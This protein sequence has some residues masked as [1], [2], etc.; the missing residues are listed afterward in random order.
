M[1]INRGFFLFISLIE[2]ASV[3]L[4]CPFS[5]L[6]VDEERQAEQYDEGGEGMMPPKNDDG[7]YEQPR[8]GE[9]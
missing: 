3:F 6:V 5:L 4:D 2:E 1:F 9:V 8:T 7:R